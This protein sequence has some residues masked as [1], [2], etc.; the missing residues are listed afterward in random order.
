MIAFLKRKIAYFRKNVVHSVLRKTGQK[1]GKGDKYHDEC[2]ALALHLP[3]LPPTYRRDTPE[4]M[5]IPFRIRVK[6]ELHILMKLVKFKKEELP[7]ERHTC[8]K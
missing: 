7:S 4:K 1:L 5:K 2:L 6:N 8:Q 3:Q